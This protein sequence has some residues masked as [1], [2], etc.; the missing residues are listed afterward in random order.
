[1]RI[2]VVGKGPREEALRRIA[3]SA[4]HT[5]PNH[6]PW[7]QVVLSLPRSEISEETADQL[8]KG[9]HV[10]C[11]MTDEA[12]DHLAKKRGWRIHRVLEDETYTLEN[13]L[14]TAE[15]AIHAAIGYSEK[16]LCDSQCLVIGF[17]RIG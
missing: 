12:F 6:G 11:G 16:A 2:F 3:L 8:P 5:L 10:I 1:M 7:D 9:Q 14:L 17:G 4:G 15:G 13:A